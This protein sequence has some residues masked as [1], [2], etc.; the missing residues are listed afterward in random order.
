MIYLPGK[1]FTIIIAV[2]KNAGLWSE[3]SLFGS[4]R[5][6]TAI[7]LFRL[8]GLVDGF[9]KSTFNGHPFYETLI[10]VKA[11]DKYTVEFKHKSNPYAINY[12]MTAGWADQIAL[13]REVVEKFGDMKNPATVRGTGPWMVKDYK[14]NVSMTWQK[15]PDYWGYDELFPDHKFQLPYADEFKPIFISD[16]SARVAAIRTAKLDVSD[17]LNMNDRGI[18]WEEKESL[19][20]NH[21]SQFCGL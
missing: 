2:G 8:Y 9:E 21:R 17:A 1:A 20:K 19:E 14:A 10:S 13:P 11:I 15:N 6:S 5:R 7:Y 16:R 12:L 4:C 18:S 3:H